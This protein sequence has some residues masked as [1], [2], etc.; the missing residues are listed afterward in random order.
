MHI[1]DRK[2]TLTPYANNWSYFIEAAKYEDEHLYNAALTIIRYARKNKLRV[3][4][5]DLRGDYGR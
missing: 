2:L 5:K 4:A 1:E 3:T